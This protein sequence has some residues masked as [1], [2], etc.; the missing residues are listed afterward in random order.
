M[1]A[2]LEKE[3]RITNTVIS[4]LSRQTPLKMSKSVFPLKLQLCL[5]SEITGSAYNILISLT[6]VLR[7][8]KMLLLQAERMENRL[9]ELTLAD[10]NTSPYRCCFNEMEMTPVASNSEALSLLPFYR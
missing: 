10:G 3:H 8:K 9:P 4:P 5:Y 7:Y 6:V 2:H 1:L